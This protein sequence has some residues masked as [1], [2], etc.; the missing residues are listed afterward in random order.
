MTN[1]PA[2]TGDPASGNAPAAGRPSSRTFHRTVYQVEV[3]SEEPLDPDLSLEDIAY[4]ITEGHCS[5]DY[6][7]TVAEEVDGPAM[8]ALLRKQ[9]SD[10]EFF[11]LTHDGRDV[12]EEES[13][14]EDDCDPGEE[15][16]Q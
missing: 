2:S 12:D 11:G 3:L 14:V 4:A 1:L 7:C 16:A 9:R 10:T 8:A 5:G 15:Q 13:D 6:Q